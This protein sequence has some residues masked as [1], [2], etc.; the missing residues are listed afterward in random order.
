MPVVS[1]FTNKGGDGKSTVTVGLAE[2]LAGN[3]GKRVLVIDLDAQAS[4]ACALLGHDSIRM[5]VGQRSGTQP[6]CFGLLVAVENTV[7]IC[8]ERCRF[9]LHVS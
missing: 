4:S 1:I 7:L 5:A 3:R 6:R 8:S 9:S 2:F